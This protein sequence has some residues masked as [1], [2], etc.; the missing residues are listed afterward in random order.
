MTLKQAHQK[1]KSATAPE[2]IFGPLAEVQNGNLHKQ[3]RALALITHADKYTKAADKKVAEEAF[4][5][6]GEWHEKAEKKLADGTYGDRTA[7]TEEVTVKTKKHTYVVSTRIESGELCE[8]YGAKDEKGNDVVLKVTRNPANNDLVTNE[9][10]RLRWLREEAPTRKLN[11]MAHLPTLLDSF[12]LKQGAASKRVNVFPHLDGYYTLEEV[13]ENYPE[14]L[15]IRDA[16]WMFNRLLGALVCIQQ[17]G[18]VHGAVIPSHIMVCPDK[19]D[20]HNGVLIDWSYAVKTGETISAVSTKYKAFYPPEVFEKKPA[21]TG[22]D[23]YMAAMC[24][25]YLLGG[26]VSARS[27]K[28]GSAPAPVQGIL[29]ACWLGPRHRTSDAFEVHK[30]FGEA[31]G[32]RK[33]RQF[34]MPRRPVATT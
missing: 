24:L 19:P 26:N 27:F 16:A 28:A 23:T 1:L 7:M 18:I 13:M 25:L 22:I 15:D 30:D 11:V 32:T 34:D 14:G 2:D 17:A 20:V 4:K 31:L 12:E 3:Y 33:F 8:V 6:L 9:A 21:T 10:E 5:L 29:R